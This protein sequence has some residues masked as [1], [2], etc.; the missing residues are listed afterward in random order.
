MANSQ[1]GVP[2]KNVVKSKKLL[3]KFCNYSE[4]GT[5]PSKTSSPSKRLLRA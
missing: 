2:T 4:G 5:P 3:K 1:K